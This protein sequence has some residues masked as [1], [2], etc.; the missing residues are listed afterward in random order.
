[1]KNA[2]PPASPRNSPCSNCQVTQLKIKILNVKLDELKSKYEAFI[3]QHASTVEENTKTSVNA[4]VNWKSHCKHI[5][6]KIKQ[7]RD[8]AT[9]TENALLAEIEERENEKDELRKRV[10]LTLSSIF[11]FLTSKIM[12][13][14]DNLTD[15]FLSH[16]RSKFQLNN[17]ER[18]IAT[19]NEELLK[20]RTE[21][22]ELELMK[23]DV[24]K[25][26]KERLEKQ[27]IEAENVMRKKI[28]EMKQRYELNYYEILRYE[29]MLKKS[30]EENTELGY[31]W[32]RAVKLLQ[33]IKFTAKEP[34]NFQRRLEEK[35]DVLMKK[36]RI[37]ANNSKTE[38]MSYVMNSFEAAVKVILS[39]KPSLHSLIKSGKDL[40][41]IGNEKINK[42]SET[43]ESRDE[44]RK[45]CV[46]K[47]KQK[48]LKEFKKF[49]SK[50]NSVLDKFYQIEEQQLANSVSEIIN[51]IEKIEQTM[52]HVSD[53]GDIIMEEYTCRNFGNTLEE[54]RNMSDIFEMLNK[55]IDGVYQEVA[56]R[57]DEK[58]KLEEIIESLNKLMQTCQKINR[59]QQELVLEL[60]AVELNYNQLYG[61]MYQLKDCFA[62]RQ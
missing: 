35:L 52:K 56:S 23:Q 21:G 11:L 41:L 59:E 54:L 42:W 60:N 16:Q 51:R 22:V 13:M 40:A 44:E 1:M 20:T 58:E 45:K 57:N 6:K 29:A 32:Q 28:M 62:Y 34:A 7:L 39:D 19:Q 9:K 46:P 43:T 61:E 14:D 8:D 3:K 4:V 18:R 36:F 33:G 12:Q 31:R 17:V 27:K 55:G 48:A 47:E 24:E 37:E 15:A 26:S 49:I 30:Y 50:I 2:S 25:R 38:M 53:V 5:E 10:M